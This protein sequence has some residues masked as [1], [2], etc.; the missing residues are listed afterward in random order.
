MGVECA[1]LTGDRQG[2]A[3]A[4]AQRTALAT[5]RG[6]L[7]PQDKAEWIAGRRRD[8]KRVVAMVGDGINDA[9]A[10]ASADV[11]IAVGQGTD[12]AV[13]TADVVLMNSSLWTIPQALKLSRDVLRTIRQNLCWAFC[14]N[15]V[16]I[17]LA[18]GLF[19]SWGVSIPPWAGA[20]AMASSSLIVVSNALRLRRNSA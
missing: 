19:S 15:V 8:G 17:P 4:V 13:D 7:L 18:A 6:G 10:L 1:M 5:A 11:G 14:Y 12:V 16:A 20:A 3:D 2:V 9:P